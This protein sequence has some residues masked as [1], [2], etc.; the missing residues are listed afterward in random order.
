MN[1]I[2]MIWFIVVMEII[3][4]KLK[5]LDS[6]FITPELKEVIDEKTLEK[7]IILGQKLVILDD[8]VLDISDF[9]YHHPGGAFLLEYNIGR[10]ISK[11]FYGS[12][13]LDGNNSKPG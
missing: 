7:R 5:S 4:R 11:F 6:D 10:D 1:W 12:Y 8:M 3:Y 9:A 13:A 2:S